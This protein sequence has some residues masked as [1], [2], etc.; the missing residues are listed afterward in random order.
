[1]PESHSHRNYEKGWWKE[2]GVVNTLR[3]RQNSFDKE[4]G[5]SVLTMT[6]KRGR[7]QFIV[8]VGQLL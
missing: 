1:L 7:K 4:M 3:Q 5:A 6:A 8:T 2:V